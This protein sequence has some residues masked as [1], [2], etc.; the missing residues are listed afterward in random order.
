MRKFILLTGLLLITG[1]T[2]F[3]QQSSLKGNIADTTDN[4]NL[5]H[6]V[7]SLL[8]P[9]DSVLVR[10]AR[11]DRQG[12]FLMSRLD[13]G[14]Y[15]LMI[16][17]PY[18]GDFFD[19]IELKPDA[20]TDL[21]KVVMIPK[22]KLLAEVIVKSGSPIRIKGDTTVYTAD[23]FKVREGA[24]VE[25]LLR[26]LPGIQV[27]KNGTIT[28]MGEKVTKVLVDGEEFFGDDPGIAT[29]NLRA[30]VVK[31][32]EVYDK[33][34]DQ[35]TFT[36]ID[37][38]V[39]DKTINLKLKDSKKK[40]YFGKVE[41]GGGVEQKY[42]NTAMANFFKNKK[43]LAGYGIMSN[44]GQTNL[45][46]NDA[47]NYGGAQAQTGM[48][49]DGG[50]YMYYGGGDD[51]NNYYGGRNG[52]PT[53]WNAG[54]HF[55][56][57]YADG[58]QSLNMGYRLSKINAPGQIRSYSQNF[59]PDSSWSTNSTT[60]TRSS[61]VRQALNATIDLKLDSMNTL[62]W[63]ARANKNH[64][65]N[66]SDYYTF[67]LNDKLDSVNNSRRL[68][69]NDINNANFNT[70]VLWQ[71][72]FKKLS[73]TLSVNADFNWIESKS[74]GY[75]LAVIN[76]FDPGNVIADRDTVDQQNL[77][78]S[79]T[80]SLNTR[81]SYTE[82]LA[83][84]MY[85]ELSYAL[86]INNN[87]NDR[88]SNAKS[89]DGKYEEVIDTLSNSFTFDTYVHTP[90]LNFRINKKKINASFG[91]R[92]GI[93]HFKQMDNTA[94]QLT[95][96]NF[97]NFFPQANITYKMKSNQNIRLYYNGSGTAPS[98]SQLQ[99]VKDNSD[100]LNVYVGN[101]DLKQSF[102]HQMSA[103][104]NFYNVLKEKGLWFSVNGN[105]TQNAFSNSS[106][107]GEGAKRTYQTV[108]VNGNHGISFNAEYNFKIDG[109]KWRLGFGPTGGIVQ[110]IDYVNYIK[111]SNRNRNIGARV[112]V[113]QYVPDK[114]NF[115][116]SPRFAFYRST[117]SL[118][119]DANASYWQL[120]GWAEGHLTFAKTF[121]I[122]SEMNYEMRQKDPRF[123]QNNNYLLWNASITKHLSKGLF[124]LKFTVN[125]ILDQNRGYQR[126]F[127]SYSFSETYY[128]TL[129][130]F[131]L[132]SFTWNFSKNGKPVKD[133]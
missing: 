100:N 20:E 51:E 27:D 24:N 67:S 102:R 30:D 105:L 61:V 81:I 31:E 13:S 49:D 52:V 19:K 95:N 5:Q 10:F 25:E 65:E 125:D 94:N 11:A 26:R 3:A 18:L 86:N 120:N 28:A 44:T 29:K 80:R 59:L 45:D 98:L 87:N 17:H 96:Y 90:G 1:I 56:D 83:K 82:P 12:N 97:I 66:K 35:A 92:L 22:S 114:F 78:K 93:N 123:P 16:T 129:R 132:L 23:S 21:G 119:S 111:N 131:Y 122:G 118:N 6:T 39:K 38:G 34:S 40:G 107:I 117:S 37:D 9:K 84:D 126:N 47:Q 57:K 104:Y 43:K 36:G 106:V 8:R 68:N 50:M 75:Q 55:S 128:N 76:L 101:Q 89:V 32:V 4:K 85:M 91:G 127:N 48:S 58:K 46:W 15:L 109:T 60:N 14:R 74:T 33:K 73:R 112:S 54:L 2:V 133:F 124:D 88:I 71:H 113:S 77:R 121:E 108:N 103:S 115:Y 64:T 110:T 130:R 42:N 7:I 116:I 99:P 79:D 62:K 53:N 41:L 69:T 72:K 70:T 63:T